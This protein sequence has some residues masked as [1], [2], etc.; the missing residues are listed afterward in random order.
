[1]EEIA[2]TERDIAETLQDMATHGEGKTA[3]RRRQLAED[4]IQGAH[5]VDKRRERLQQLAEQWSEHAS[6]VTLHQLLAHAA[7]VLTELA[8]TEQDIADTFSD[9]AHH[10]SSLL[11]AQRRQLAKAAAADAQSARNRAQDLQ[12]LVRASA[13][14]RPH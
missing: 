11:A 13:S 10:D 5:E 2:H 14:T 3:A 7:S 4:A 6:V 1:M 12:Q 8:R 9:L